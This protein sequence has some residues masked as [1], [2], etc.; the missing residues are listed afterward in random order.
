M[1]SKA[2]V[3]H[4]KEMNRLAEKIRSIKDSPHRRDL[5]REW[6]SMNRDLKEFDRLRRKE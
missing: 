1:K 4:V 2:R 6:D 3:R 5:I